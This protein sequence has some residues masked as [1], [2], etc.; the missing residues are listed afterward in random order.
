M[1]LLRLLNKR[2]HHMATHIVKELMLKADDFGLM[3]VVHYSSRVIVNA[4]A[5]Q[6]NAAPHFRVAAAACHPY[7]QQLVKLANFLKN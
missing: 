3:L 2:C 5:M 6:Q 4:M 1:W 7:V